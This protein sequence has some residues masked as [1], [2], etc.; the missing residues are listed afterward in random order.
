[1]YRVNVKNLW[2]RTETEKISK[3][4]LK[5]VRFGP[6]PFVLRLILSV[7]SCT[8]LKSITFELDIDERRTG[9]AERNYYKNNVHE[10]YQNY[11]GQS[12]FRFYS[13]SVLFYGAHIRLLGKIVKTFSRTRFSGN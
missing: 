3:I 1:M 10:P 9:T 6:L 7:P 2:N 5:H 11:H 13:D 8:L 4:T 12:K